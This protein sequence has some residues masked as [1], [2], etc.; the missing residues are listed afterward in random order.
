L[1]NVPPLLGPYHVHPQLQVLHPSA[2]TYHHLFS[3]A[4]RTGLS[5]RRFIP[6]TL[7]RSGRGK[8]QRVVQLIFSF[9]RHVQRARP[10]HQ[11][12]PQPQVLHPSAFTYHHHFSIALRTGSS[13]Q[14]FIPNTPPRRGRG[15]LQ[16]VVQLIFSFL[17][18]VQQ[19]RLLHQL[20][21][22]NQ[23]SPQPQRLVQFVLLMRLSA[24]HLLL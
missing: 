15:K 5:A 18:H 3:I 13:A 10:L 21:H 24:R 22:Q 23:L 7:P 4:L 1:Y 9:L 19:A 11:L 14:R 12:P 2:F 16:R 17:R 6:N 20:P 8:L